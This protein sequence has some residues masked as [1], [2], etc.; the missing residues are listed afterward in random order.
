[1]SEEYTLNKFTLGYPNI[2][3]TTTDMWKVESLVKNKITV[4]DS[5]A[6]MSVATLQ[7]TVA[8]EPTEF[9]VDSL[10]AVKATSVNKNK[11]YSSKRSDKI[12]LEKGLANE[13]YT[14]IVRLKDLPVATYNGNVAGFAATNPQ[15]SK[16]ALFKQLA[17]SKKSSQQIRKELRLDLDAPEVKA[18]SNYLE[19][20]QQVFLS[21][22]NSKLGRNLNVIYKYKN[23]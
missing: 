7:A 21:K 3:I 13:Q 16:K 10:K 18:Y 20:K 17:N 9:T 15:V 23:E 8:M 1:M 19:N 14:Y 2:T 11:S 5:A 22:A 4:A 6:L 12:R